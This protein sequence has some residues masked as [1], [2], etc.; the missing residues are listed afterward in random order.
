M[1]TAAHKNHKHGGRKGRVEG[2]LPERGRL[3]GTG[4]LRQSVVTKDSVEAWM[5]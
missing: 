3:G 5:A 1:G 4:T 2:W